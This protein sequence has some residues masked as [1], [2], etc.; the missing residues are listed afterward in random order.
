MDRCDTLMIGDGLNDAPAFDVAFC[1]GAAALDR[2][3]MPARA[4][5]FFLGGG[6]TAVRLILA[7]AKRLHQVVTTNLW[8]AASYNIVALTLC[9]LGMMT[10]L[11]CAV[12]MPLSSLVLV[13][14]SVARLRA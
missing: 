14:H 9:F 5:F 8:L 11:L 10:P 7:T 2:P 4:D 13:W 12:L 6:S 3:V 1:A